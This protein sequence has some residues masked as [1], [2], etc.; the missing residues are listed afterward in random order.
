MPSEKGTGLEEGTGLGLLLVKQFLSDNK[1]KLQVI[2]HPEDG[3]EFIVS[4]EKAK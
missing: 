2:N 4:F 3:T 1:G